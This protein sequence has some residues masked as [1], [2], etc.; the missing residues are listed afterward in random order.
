MSEGGRYDACLV[1][2]RDAN[3]IR[4]SL[5]EMRSWSRQPDAVIVLDN[6]GDLPGD[7]VAGDGSQAFTVT[8]VD[9]GGNV[10]YAAA[11]N[12]AI[13]ATAAR[14]TPYLLLLTQD[15]RLDSQT[16]EILARC[17]DE[18][19]TVAVAAPIL[20]LVSRPGIT[21]S[22]GGTLSARARTKHLQ[23]GT[24]LMK[25][26]HESVRD[27]DWVDGACQMVRVS[28]AETVGGLPEEYFLY[29]EEIDFQHRLRRRN[30]RVVVVQRARAY[31]EPG[32]YTPYLKYRNLSHFSRKYPASFKRWPWQLVLV[33]DSRTALARRRPADVAWAIRGVLD[34]R[35]GRMGP[36][37]EGLFGR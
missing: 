4:C 36:P 11:A 18:D 10:G 24:P 9:P 1:H 19:E 2:Y 28:D 29:I 6:S 26:D 13:A 14:G 8:V 5:S 3:S 21:F 30:K 15:A 34:A 23:Q 7:I 32:N 20:G 31:Q 16:A 35:R 25:T 27:V 37:P 17:L 22:A 33:R 12:R